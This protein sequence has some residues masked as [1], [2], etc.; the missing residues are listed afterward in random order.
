MAD[1][2][3]EVPLYLQGADLHNIGN[4]GQSWF[5]PTTW[6]DRLSNGFSFAAT[7]VASGVAQLYN[8]GVTVGKMAGADL[9]EIDTGK[10]ITEFDSDLGKY[11]S[12]NKDSA[13]MWGFILSSFVPGSAGVKIFNAGQ[14][15]VEGAVVGGKIAGNMANATKLLVPR[16]EM[17]IQEAAQAINQSQATFSA[18][19]Q[20]G[21]KALLSGVQQNALEAMA[22]ETAVQATMFKSPVLENQSVGEVIANIALGGAVG[23][24]IGG[25]IQGVGTVGKIS[26]QVKAYELSTKEDTARRGIQAMNDPAAT[27]ALRADELAEGT[28]IPPLAAGA[29]PEEQALYIKRVKDVEDRNMRDALEIRTNFNKLNPSEDKTVSNLAADMQAG[30]TGEQTA[31]WISHT[32]KVVRVGQETAEEAAANAEVKAALK[33][34]RAPDL[35]GHQVSYLKVT[36]EGA[37]TAVDAEPAILRWA[38]R[39]HV[40]EGEKLVDAV[41]RA[42]DNYGFRLG[43]IWDPTDLK[44][45][46]T[47]LKTSLKEL[48]AEAE[49]RYIWAMDRVRD[50]PKIGEFFAHGND[51]PMVQRALQDGRLDL[52]IIDNSGKTVKDGF[53]SRQEM[54]EYLRDTKLEVANSLMEANK[55]PLLKAKLEAEAVAKI[56]DTRLSR[57]MGT[58]HPDETR[59]FF[60]T[61]TATEDLAA[62]RKAKGLPDFKEGEG[63]A[64]YQP[65]YIKLVKDVPEQMLNGHVV[66]ALAFYKAQEVKFTQDM[67]RVIA[68]NAA[69]VYDQLPTI[70][71]KLL[72][73]ANKVGESARFASYANGG[74]GT[75]GSVMQAI[76]S[77]TRKL[78]ESFRKETGDTFTGVLTALG[79]NQDAV[80]EF[81]TINQ[82]VT[83]SAK[84][85]VRH[86]DEKGVEHLITTDARTALQKNPEWVLD[87][88][89]DLGAIE[90][91][92]P[93]TAQAIDAMISRTQK[94]T[95]AYKELRAAQ[96]KT[97]NKVEDVFRP[98]RPD[99]KDYPNFA[100]VVD[101]KVTGQGHVTM[102]FASTPEKLSQLATKAEQTGYKVRFKEDTE[103]FK[104]AYGDY[105]YA[106]TL[107]ESY[108]DSDLKNR[109]VFS[110]HFTKTDPQKTIDDV[111]RQHMRE[112]DVLAMEL[113]RGKNQKAF[114]FLEDQGKAYS[115][116]ESSK[117]GGS[118]RDVEAKGKNPYT[119]YIKTALDISNTQSSMLYGFNKMLDDAVSKAVSAIKSMPARSTADLEQINKSLQFYGVDTAFRG[120]ADELLINHTAPKGELTKFVRSANAILS[121]LTLGLDPLNALNNAIGANVLRGTEL[122][123]I[124]R[125][126]SSGNSE[127]A[128]ELSKLAKVALPGGV[129]EIT[130]PSKLVAG[131][132]KNFFADG[133]DGPL[134]TRYKASGYIKDL[135]TQFHDII[136]DFTLK[137]TETVQDLTT[138]T[139]R[140]IAK[141]NSMSETGEKL[142]GNALAEEFNRFVSAD[143]MRQITDLAE[144]HNLLTRA[145]SHAYINTFVN[146]VEGNTIASQRPLVFQGPV[147]QAVGLFQSYQFNLMQQLFRYTAEGTAKDTAM[148][149]GLQG[150]FYGLNGLP[151]FQFMNQHV[152]GTM[153]GNKKHIDAYDAVYAGAGKQVG[154][155]VMYGLPSDLLRAN[156]YSRGDINPRHLTVIPT[157]IPDIPFVGALGK[158]LGSMKDTA[159]RIGAGGQVW[160]SMLQGLEHN[161]VS[162]PL[163][164]L[165]QTLQAA[166]PGGQVYSTTSK[167]S[168]LFSNDLMSWATAVRIAGGRPFDEAIVNDG[169]FRIHSY[170]QADREKRKD[171][172]SAIKTAG[173]QGNTPDESSMVRFAQA[174]AASG[175]KQMNFNKFMMNEM[176]AANTNEANK[177]VS[178]LQN[179][180]AQKVQ[181]LMGGS[182][183]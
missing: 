64:F 60:A 22:F 176:K 146:R 97:D 43:K 86:T 171:L 51:L 102:I 79:K 50:L 87:D 103:E 136:D 31:E 92:N 140:A 169:L 46:T 129:G 82:T 8:T 3:S 150:T 52:R 167:G 6:G 164:G 165:A 91:T 170:Q 61:R 122:T 100:F 98:I 152:I 127:L 104:R 109:G 63:S 70:P 66:D 49:A 151:G 179:P 81:N 181:I 175:G 121:K 130:S 139:N 113:V 13:D 40:R 55:A 4:S 177:I 114:D 128:G 19:N 78:K 57:L 153:S 73:S 67:E 56:V 101:P 42:V 16:T 133:K 18:I 75:L 158:L 1:D 34:N 163:A 76:G 84:L 142:T 77:A 134:H 124:T 80:V 96:G 21:I 111:L 131:A 29:T 174:Y 138:R 45:G 115:K 37:G 54:F 28:K 15:V 93:E 88:V 27:I 20:A 143:V 53:A 48:H 32:K 94:R 154:D 135:T 14:K 148:L 117:F 41:N 110:E 157:S 17:Y 44:L 39:V 58:I 12:Q 141:L 123:Q 119:D 160:E 137:G 173:I 68:K 9:D 116:I 38:D 99:P 132:I 30:Q 168:I 178:Q 180:L 10:L 106:K 162:R 172:A 83:R 95:L 126:I 120:T 69:A 112:D 89:A 72:W 161:G 147:G 149:L 47:Q 62:F 90:I 24:V 105:E 7:A 74:Y 118:I 36:G 26:K 145:E 182:P 23:G 11:Y 35:G 2:F 85:W 107:H 5:D 155:L 159:D 156:L 65:S 144:K 125:A 166:G 59:D 183:E 71:E 108:I 33:E 25:V